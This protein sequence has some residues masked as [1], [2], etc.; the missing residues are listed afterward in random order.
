MTAHKRWM[1]VLGLLVVAAAT[2]SDTALGDGQPQ[3]QN[4][5]GEID[6]TLTSWPPTRA[7]ARRMDAHYILDVDDPSLKDRKT[8]PAASD[9]LYKLDPNQTSRVGN[10][11]IT[12]AN[13]RTIALE[14]TSPPQRALQDARF[15]GTNCVGLGDVMSQEIQ[16]L[17]QTCS[18]DPAH[19][20]AARFIYQIKDNGSVECRTLV[21][22]P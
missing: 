22:S 17:V 18:A 20:G 3:D 5:E 8:L 9:L 2:S 6:L 21:C 12:G 7:A 19:P 16:A 4:Q 11:T 10:L 13:D 1:V 14:I 15:S